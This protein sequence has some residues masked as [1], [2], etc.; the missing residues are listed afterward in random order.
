VA[1]ESPFLARPPTEWLASNAFAF[2]LADAFPVSPG[3]ALVIPRRLVPTWFDASRDEQLAILDLI[4][5]LKRRIDAERHPDGYNV[6]FN[7]GE[8]SCA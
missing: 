5:E 2:A 7:A 8:A 3:H 4:N 6:G 1:A